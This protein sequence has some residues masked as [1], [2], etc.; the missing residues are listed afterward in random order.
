MTKA[1]AATRIRTTKE[2]E[3][4]AEKNIPDNCEHSELQM[5]QHGTRMV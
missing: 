3:V 2:G 1:V 5:R 4:M